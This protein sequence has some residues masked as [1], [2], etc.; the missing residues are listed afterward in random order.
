M[1]ERTKV[2]CTFRLSEGTVSDLKH[3]CELEDISQ[4]EMITILVGGYR[5]WRD[6]KAGPLGLEDVVNIKLGHDLNN[7]PN[8][9]LLRNL[10]KTVKLEDGNG[11]AITFE[12]IE[13]MEKEWRGLA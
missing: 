9:N 13:K 4:A 10:V 3:L 2:T 12:Q 11:N 7:V 1:S 5:Q 8:F 6:G